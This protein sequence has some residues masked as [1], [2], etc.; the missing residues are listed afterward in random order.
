MRLALLLST[1]VGLALAAWLLGHIGWAAVWQP[2]RAIGYGGFA[3]Y[4]AYTLPVLTA[5]GAAWWVVAP[6]SAPGTLPVFVWGRATREAATDLLPFAQLGG[7]VVGG[8]SVAA[9]GIAAP[10]AYASMI[11]DLTTEMASQLV[12][13]LAGI[14]ALTAMLHGD[15][16]VHQTTHAAAVGI[17]L[18][19]LVGAAFAGL[20]RPLIALAG[21]LLDRVLPGSAIRFDAVRAE[22]DRIYRQRGRV[23]ASFGLNLAAW[24]LSGLGAW[25]ALRLA[26]QHVAWTSVLIVES[27]IFAL[28]SAAFIVPGAIGVQEAAYVLLCPLF[29]LPPE[30]GLALSLLKRARDVAVGLP[31]LIAWQ[32][33]EGGAL[34]R[35]RAGLRD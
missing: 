21:Q 30:T 14:A 3:L 18:I 2:V 22:L 16:S 32:A 31:V 8:R 23:L 9:Q 24:V 27:L 28:R 26:G 17:A 19:L 34:W 25:L 20:Q 11:A 10:L 35:A 15:A 5:L 13:T 12:F 33:H 6:G 7:L 1:V 4:V 29:G